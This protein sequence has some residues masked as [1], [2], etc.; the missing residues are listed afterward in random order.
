MQSNSAHGFLHIGELSFET[1]LQFTNLPRDTWLHC[2]HDAFLR[3]TNGVLQSRRF[4]HEWCGRGRQALDTNDREKMENVEEALAV[5][6]AQHR[7]PSVLKAGFSELSKE[8]AEDVSFKQAWLTYIWRR[9][10]RHEIEPEIADER[11]QYW[12]SHNSKT[13]SSQDAVDV[14]RGLAEVRKLG[15][16]AQLWDESRKE[17]EQDIDNSKVPSRSDF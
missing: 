13:P 15:I 8:E 12:I 9:A 4:C 1:I 16:E 7:R 17:L 11:L 3:L 5:A 2:R 14:E 6:L 10:K